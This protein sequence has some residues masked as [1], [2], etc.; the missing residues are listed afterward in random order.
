MQDCIQQPIEKTIII[1]HDVDLLPGNSLKMA[2]M[3]NS[4]NVNAC[5][6]FRIVKESYDEDIIR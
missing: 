4:E 1:R 2:R 3:E 5:Y 6:Y